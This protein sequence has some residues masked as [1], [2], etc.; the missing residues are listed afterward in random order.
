MLQAYLQ[1]KKAEEAALKDMKA[2]AA[3]KGGFAKAGKK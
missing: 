3:Q 2:K 1:K